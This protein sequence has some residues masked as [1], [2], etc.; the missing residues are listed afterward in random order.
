LRGRLLIRGFVVAA[1]AAAALT[2][3]VAQAFA[4]ITFDGS[5]GT[6]PP[7]PTLG[8]YPMT[9][10]PPDA[11]PLFQNVSG[12]PSPLGGTVGFS[13][14]LNHRRIGNGW[15]TWSHGY[16]GDVYYTNGALSA[17]LTMP[18]NTLA[19]Y[20]YAEPNPFA[21][22]NIT[23]TANDGTTSGPV[24][25]NGAAG[26][27]YFGFYATNGQT[28]AS[29]TV[30]STTDFAVGEFGIFQVTCTNFI[31]GSPGPDILQG[32]P[33]DDCIFGLGGNDII[34]GR[35]GN[36]FISGGPGDDTI[37]GGLGDDMILGD[38]DN[39][40]VFGGPGNDQLLAG[41][42]GPGETPSANDNLYGESGFDF[43][44]GGVGIDVCNGGTETDTADGSCESTPGV[45]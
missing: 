32:T 22:I 38:Q 45:P 10:F 12:V 17:T 36:D 29:I 31:V 27:Q 30:T 4:D 9:P 41:A 18:A 2:W 8:G 39:D 24:P 34:F 43:L 5:P 20:L 40:I 3:G 25:V 7:P 14:V 23:A 26:A 13:P 44:Q 11:R 15:A 37:Y 21:V 35:T 19:F 1:V 33:A 16:T 42:D 6:G 28:L